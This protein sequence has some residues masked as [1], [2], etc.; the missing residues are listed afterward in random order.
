[1]EVDIGQLSLKNLHKGQV[2]TTFLKKRKVQLVTINIIIAS[3]HIK[4]G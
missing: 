3:C 2:S 4:W 1:M